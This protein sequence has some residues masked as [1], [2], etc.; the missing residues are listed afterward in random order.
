MKDLAELIMKMQIILGQ[1]KSEDN[2]DK[3]IDHI[4]D[5]Y[6]ENLKVTKNEVAILLV[7]DEKTVLSFAAPKYLINS[8]LI[9]VSS[10]DAVASTA[11]RQGDSIIDNNFHS[12]KHLALFEIIKTPDNQVLTI[13]KIMIT[14]IAH[15]NDKL[16]II[17]ISRRAKNEM[18]AGEDFTG[19]ELLFLENSIRE[20]APFIKKAMPENFRG[21]L[22]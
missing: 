11:F 21:K 15:K 16:G 3:L 12:K 17:E 19:K 13:W 2:F 4:I 14:L 1:E 22:T 9:P 10:I 5:F 20:I 18:G 8:G 7:N 6:I